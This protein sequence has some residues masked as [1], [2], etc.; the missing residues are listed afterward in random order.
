LRVGGASAV[1]VV[2]GDAVAAGFRGLGKS[3]LRSDLNFTQHMDHLVDA[4]ADIP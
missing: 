1:V 4:L 3:F 2:S